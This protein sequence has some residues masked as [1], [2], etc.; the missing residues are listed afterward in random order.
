MWE[1]LVDRKRDYLTAMPF[2]VPG[3]EALWLASNSCSVIG[4]VMGHGELVE[5]SVTGGQEAVVAAADVVARLALLCD[6][7]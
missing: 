6:T 4:R 1:E 5:V 7:V 3:G 2:L